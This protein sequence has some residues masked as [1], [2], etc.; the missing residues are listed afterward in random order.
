MEDA[1]ED[2][3]VKI[4]ESEKKASKDVKELKRRSKEKLDKSEAEAVRK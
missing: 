1:D 3:E 4:R 2:A